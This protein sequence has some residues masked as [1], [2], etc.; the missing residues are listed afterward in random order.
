MTSLLSLL[1]Y[2][3]TKIR[4]N[5]KTYLVLTEKINFENQMLVIQHTQVPATERKEKCFSS[6]ISFGK[7]LHL[8]DCVTLFSKSEVTLIDSRQNTNTHRQKI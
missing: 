1:E 6:D 7:N 4:Y 5:Y 8:V 3:S 2:E